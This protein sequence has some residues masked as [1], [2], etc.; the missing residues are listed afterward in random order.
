V[1]G[2][3]RDADQK[4][5]KDAFRRLS[6][7]FHPDRNKSPDAEE[8]FKEIAEAYAVL[9]DPEKRAEYDARGFAGVAGFSR[10]DLF[11][12][13]NFEDIFG[14]FDFDF[15]G[16][17]FDQLFRRRRA[18]PGRGSNVEVELVVT[19]QRIASGG[20][21][22][23][24]LIRPDTC[25]TCHGSG[26]AP[27]TS[28]RTC[29]ACGGT[30]QQRKSHGKGKGNV[31]IQQIIT[32]PVCGGRGQVIDHPCPTCQGRGEVERQEVLKVT[33]PPGIEEGMA[34]R[35]PGHGMPSREGGPAGD[36]FVVVRS[37]PDPRFVRDGPD[38]WYTETISVTDA[39]LGTELNI[40]TLDGGATVA[41][42]P[43]TQPDAVLRLR[44]KGLPEFGGKGRGDLYLRLR[45]YIPEHL[46]AEE[47]ELY[48]R[49]R[50]FIPKTSGPR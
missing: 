43:G 10:E 33:V 11:S 30:G 34:L 2:I 36:L 4:A 3:A 24:R 47:R 44:G 38:L 27:G 22:E 25:P 8:K 5:I 37:A 15:G 46:T 18:G 17:L 29:E 6:L 40:P 50:T 23:V 13:I 12:G 21:E 48:T 32:C 20:E 39:V 41:I 31:V 14:G 1:L 9:S 35:V 16:G 45:I 49:L 7:Q 28:P 42:P 26:A 19:L